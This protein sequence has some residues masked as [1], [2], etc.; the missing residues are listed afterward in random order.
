MRTKIENTQRWHTHPTQNTRK[1]T[2]HLQKHRQQ[3]HEQAV[4]THTHD[5]HAVHETIAL[6][7]HTRDAETHTIGAQKVINIFKEIHKHTASS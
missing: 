5:T 7:T 1:Y 3:V 6:H 2:R 4:E